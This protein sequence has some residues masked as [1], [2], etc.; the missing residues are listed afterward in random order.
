V[1][2]GSERWL[3]AGKR[4]WWAETRRG[5]REKQLQLKPSGGRSKE[6]AEAGN[7]PLEGRS[8]RRGVIEAAAARN[9]WWEVERGSRGLGHASGG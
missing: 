4:L 9:E 6:A 3:G 5:G 7:M 8:A 1:V 2:G